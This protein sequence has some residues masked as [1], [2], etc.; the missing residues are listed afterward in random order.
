[1]ISEVFITTLDGQL[2]THKKYRKDIRCNAAEVFGHHV[3]KSSPGSLPPYWAEEG[4]H[5]FH[6]RR[7]GLY[8]AAATHADMMPVFLIEMLSR[9]FHVIKD[10][11]GVVNEAALRANFVLVSEVLEEFID[12]GHIQLTSTEKLKSYIQSEAVPTRAEGSPDSSYSTALFGIEKRTIPSSAADRPVI[13]SRRDKEVRKNEIFIDVVERMTVMIT[14]D[15]KRVRSEVS[16]S[17]NMKSF[18]AGSPEIKLGF[19]DDLAIGQK[20]AGVSYG[21]NS[22]LDEYSFH[23]CVKPSAFEESRIIVIQPPQGEV[24]VMS[25][26]LRGDLPHSL[27]FTLYPNIDTTQRDMELNLRL[28][29]NIPTSTHALN[30]HVNLPVPRNVTSVSQ[31]LSGP[32]QTAEF[33]ASKNLLCWNIRK[34]YGKTEITAKFKLI[35]NSGGQAKINELGPASLDFEISGF[36]CSNLQVPD[37][38]KIIYTCHRKSVIFPLNQYF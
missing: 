31:Q 27:P 18:L 19:N 22:R 7:H 24:A 34:L 28:C 13:H 5:F 21:S 35:A 6:I 30:I 8:I 38:Q 25:Y 11:C 33:T 2:I 14:N 1:M 17:V 16:G 10:L 23:E 29:C 20:N 9:L 12:C 36:V 15:E 26:C 32:E 37:G 4:A 3:R